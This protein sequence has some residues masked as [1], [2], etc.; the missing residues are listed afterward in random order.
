[1]CADWQPRAAGRVPV[2]AIPAGPY[3][4][5]ASGAALEQFARQVA[6]L[7]A[8]GIAVREEQ[9]PGDFDEV[10]RALYVITRYELARGHARWHARHPDGY[11]PQTVAMIGAGQAIGAAEY[12]AAVRFQ[13]SFAAQVAAEMAGRGVDAWITPAATGP[14]PAGLASTGD[15]VMSVPWSLAGLPAVSVPAGQ[16][17]ALPLGLQCAGRPHADEQLVADAELIEGALAR[18]DPG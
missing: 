3:L 17:G 14:A 7:R 5:A 6:C 15:P 2:L 10:M 18:P 11:R 1:V 8:A 9:A 13:A 12:A 4:E 16:A